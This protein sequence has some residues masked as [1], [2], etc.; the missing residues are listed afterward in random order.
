MKTFK[1][2]YD[3]TTLAEVQVD[4]EKAAKIIRE[5]VDFWS[6]SEDRLKE[7]DGDYLRTWLKQLGGF[8]LSHRRPPQDDEGWYNLDGTWGIKLVHWEE[9]EFDE[10]M[11]EIEEVKP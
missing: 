10:G 8:I 2:E 1:I 5:M 6:G 4:E 11:I 9:Y 3:Y 7:N